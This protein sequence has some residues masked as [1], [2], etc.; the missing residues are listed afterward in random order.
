[1]NYESILSEL[2]EKGFEILDGHLRVK[3]ALSNG[4]EVQALD[5]NGT[6]YMISIKDG[7]LHFKKAEFSQA[8]KHFGRIAPSIIVRPTRQ[9]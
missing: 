3:V 6:P 1:M 9:A 4:F 5:G 8:D 2:K 7:V